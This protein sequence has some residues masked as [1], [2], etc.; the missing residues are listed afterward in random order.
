MDREMITQ[1][2]KASGVS[3][4]E[5]VLVHFWGEDADKAIANDFVLAVARWGATPLLLQQS[6]LLNRELFS[7][8]SESCYG[9]RYFD[10]FS[11]FDAVLDVFTYRPVVLGCEIAESQFALYRRY[12]ARLFSKLTRCKRFAQIRV[13]TVAN[14]EESGL[15]PQDYIRRMEQAY[16]VDY[17]ALATACEAA[18]ARFAGARRVALHTGQG[19]TLTFDLTD[20]AWHVDAGDGD[21]PCGEVYIAPVEDKTQGTV[22]F[23]TLYLDGARYP[24]VLLHIRDGAVCGSDQPDVAAFFARQPPENRVVCELGLGMNPQVTDLCGYTV[25]DE[26]MHGTFHIAVGDNQLFGGA[27]AATLHL[28]LVGHGQI[29]C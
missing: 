3:P 2:V 20:R 25:L 19:H 29:E 8:A 14:A 11:Q 9:E 4:G 17:T 12:M 6:R 18:V 13:P 22:Y 26:K 28:D 21:W 16:R 7:A 27:N 23:E 15:A 24:Q 1:I 10:L 5:M